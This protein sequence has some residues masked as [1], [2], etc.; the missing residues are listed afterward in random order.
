[1]GSQCVDCVRAARPPAAERLRRWNASKPALLTSIIVAVNVAV[2]IAIALQGGLLGGA[3]E[4]H[5]ELALFGPAVAAGEWYR[6]VTSG[7][8]HF[9]VMHLAFNMLIIWQLGGL[10]ERSV[11]RLRFGLVYLASLL[12]GSA[13]ALLLA[14]NS[15]TAG[16]SGAAFGL[17]GA[18]AVGMQR[19]G[20]NVLRTELGT[21]LLL[22]LVITFAVPGISIGG[23]LGG[24]IGGAACGYVLLTPSRR[25][26]VV[27]DV[28]TPL[29]VMVGAV[30]LAA[31]AVA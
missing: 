12:A 18:V 5:R 30:V 21:L 10:L 23:H 26:H 11:G 27:W 24:L 29:A 8:V 1:M 2:F 15:L 28:A 6:L 19:R 9:G 20:V 17:L 13:G 25:P 31:Y 3:T 16:A 4:V 22:N 7:F 14:P